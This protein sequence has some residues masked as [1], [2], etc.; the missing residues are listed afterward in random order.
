[1]YSTVM[2]TD[3]PKQSAAMNHGRPPRGGKAVVWDGGEG[4]EG[5]RSEMRGVG[6]SR[7]TRGE[8]GCRGGRGAG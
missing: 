7:A 1:M 4:R 3:H 5:G 2:N 8:I 6:M